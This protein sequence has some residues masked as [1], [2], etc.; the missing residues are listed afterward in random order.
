MA[1]WSSFPQVNDSE[2]VLLR[3]NLGLLRQLDRAAPVDQ[4]KVMVDSIG[5]K[6]VS[7]ASGIGGFIADTRTRDPVQAFM[8]AAGSV[9]MAILPGLKTRNA[10]PALAVGP[11]PLFRWMA[12]TDSEP[13]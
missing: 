6:F 7:L 11:Y 10:A 4:I 12:T 1:F 9:R 8:I 13:A 3:E 5:P 2:A